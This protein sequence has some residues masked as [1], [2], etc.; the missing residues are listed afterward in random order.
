[1]SEIRVELLGGFRVGVDGRAVDESAWHRKKPAALIK[2]LALAPAH[3]L[4]RAQ[5]IDTLWP[6]LDETA[7]GANLRKAIFQARR[8]VED[9]GGAGV[10]TSDADVVRLAG[11]PVSVDLDEFRAAVATGRRDGDVDAYRHAVELYR[12]GLLPED[13]F[14]EWAA[15]QADAVG[16][17]YLAILEELVGL[18]EGRGDI[19]PAIDVAKTLVDAEPLREDNHVTLIRLNALAG[20]RGEALR[21]YD[22]LNETLLDELGTEPGPVASQLYEEIRSRNALEPELAA[23][24]WERVGDL[25]VLSGDAEGAAHAYATVLQSDESSDVRARLERKCADAWL[26]RHRPDRA[27]EHI[28]AALALT[29]DPAELARLRRTQANHRWETGDIPAAQAFAEQA[30]ELAVEHGD[31]DDIAA[32]Q[33]ALAIVSHFKGEWRDGL[34]SELDRLASGE[35]GTTELARVFDLHHCIGQYHLYGDGLAGS[36]E[37]YA[38]RIL[39]R[40][41][42]AGA[43]RAQ[44]FAWCLLGESLLLQARFDEAAGCLER[45]C[46]LH[47]SFGTRS[48]GLPWQRRAEL[49]VCTGATSDVEPYLRR[50]SGIATVSAMAAHVWGRIYATRAFAALE[51]GSPGRAVE[52]VRAAAASAQ[53][54][55]DCPSCSALLNPV[56]AEAFAL[57]GDAASAHTYAAHAEQVGQMFASSAWQAM[58]LSAAGSAASADGDHDAARQRFDEAAQLYTKAGQPYWAGWVARRNAQGTPVS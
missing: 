25:R 32:A 11:D 44:A 55:G 35:A 7:G 19:G 45:S 42:D 16:L 5:L 40:A 54:Y 51:A 6:E 49:A 2:L 38:R 24:L 47:E 1:V 33:E 58:A 29:R 30:R 10:L 39:D 27:A 14:E 18:L 56:A 20:R 22:R 36:V 46:A 43:V 50:A 41:E 48:G 9:A 53:R 15:S 4:H 13:R 37:G 12:T 57:L 26:G 8:A 23:D 21:A 17:E 31:P 34:A 3:R 52:A 28:D